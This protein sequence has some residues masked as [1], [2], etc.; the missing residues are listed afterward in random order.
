MAYASG[1]LWLA[2]NVRI[3]LSDWLRERGM[4]TDWF[5][6]KIDKRGSTDEVHEKLMDE[7]RATCVG[8]SRGENIR[9]EP[10]VSAR[11]R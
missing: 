5:P 7:A 8:T 3:L 4:M 2:Q 9:A 1:L 10:N 11:D 6:L